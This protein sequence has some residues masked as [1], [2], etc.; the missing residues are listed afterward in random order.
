MHSLQ[1]LN[2]LNQRAVNRA[3]QKAAPPVAPS[4]ATKP[5]LPRQ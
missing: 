1:T 3:A 4:P 5:E 2:K